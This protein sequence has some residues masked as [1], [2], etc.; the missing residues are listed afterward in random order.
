MSSL[1]SESQTRVRKHRAAMRK[2]GLRPVQLWV[3]DTRNEHFSQEAAR[4][5][6]LVSK[7][8]AQE[9][10]DIAFLEQATAEIEGWE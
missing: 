4:Q 8:D 1:Q 2:A 9:P 3:P 10:D 5:S 6:R 7:H